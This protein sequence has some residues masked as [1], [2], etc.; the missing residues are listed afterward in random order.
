MTTKPCTCGPPESPTLCAAHPMDVLFIEQWA[1]RLAEDAKTQG[2]NFGRMS[3]DYWNGKL[4]AYRELLQL[5]RLAREV[6]AGR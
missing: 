3:A 1:R 4:T 5:I 6:E 2:G